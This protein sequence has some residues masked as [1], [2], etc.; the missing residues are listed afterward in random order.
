MSSGNYKWD[1]NE[2]KENPLFGPDK[3][4]RVVLFTSRN[5]D[6]SELEN[7]SERRRAFLSTKE[8]S[9]IIEEFK[10]SFMRKSMPG[11]V[12]RVYVSLNARDSKKIQKALIHFLLDAEDLNLAS[13]PVKLAALAAQKENAL[14]K[15]WFFDFDAPAEMLPE[16]LEDVEMEIAATKAKQRDP[17]SFRS[18]ILEARPTVSGHAVVVSRPFDSSKLLQKWHEYVDLKRDDLLFLYHGVKE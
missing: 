11:E 15:K 6:N 13:L 4:L 12:S 8:D 9:E 1:K 14:E 3:K 5:K 17:E 7:F 10:D 18:E 16:F 2:G